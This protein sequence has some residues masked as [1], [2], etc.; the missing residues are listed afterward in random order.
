MMKTENIF[1]IVLIFCIFILVAF[2]LIHPICDPDIFFH[3]GIGRYIFENLK[4]PKQDIFSYTL[5]G[6]EYID[7]HWL[8]QVMIYSIYKFFNFTGLIIFKTILVLTTIFLFFNISYKKERYLAAALTFFLPILILQERSDFRPE[9][10][11][12]F[13]SSVYIYIINKKERLMWLIPFLQIFW[14]NLHGNLSPIGLAI[15]FF[16]ALSNGKLYKILVAAV[17]SCIINPWGYKYFYFVLQ[18]VFHIFSKTDILGRTIGEFQKPFGIQ[19]MRSSLMF[20]YF[21]LFSTAIFVIFYIRK[22]STSELLIY[23]S[24]VILSF[25]AVRNIVLFSFIV[26]PIVVKILNSL[27]FIKPLRYGLGALIIIFCGYF[28]YAITSNKVYYQYD[29]PKKFG[30]GISETFFQEK[31]CKFILEKNIEGNIFH[32]MATGDSI[33]LWLYPKKKVFIDA[34]PDARIKVWKNLAFTYNNIFLN[35]EFFKEILNRYEIN[36]IFL[37]YTLPLANMLYQKVAKFKDW[38]LVYYDNNSVIFLRDTKMGLTDGTY[39]SNDYLTHLFRAQFYSGLEDTDKALYE[40]KRAIILNPNS[41]IANNNLGIIYLQKDDYE[42]ALF[43][44][45]KALKYFKD[46]AQIYNNLGII[47]INTREF[48]KARETLKVGIRKNPK[49]PQL[50]YN[51]GR[52]CQTKGFIEKATK[53][54]QIALQ[55]DPEYESP[56]RALEELYEKK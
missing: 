28:S 42:N 27:K 1:K 49:I 30:F 40:Y 31:A 35:M 52:L 5:S 32:D 18:I 29:I 25:Q 15:I 26:S 10:V 22:L 7:F 55:L 36:C 50:H 37:N 16:Y 2:F 6:A 46:S 23:V 38:K 19:Q 33:I 17:F 47:Y 41:A 48:E 12:L 4:I 24:F 53:E 9:V 54:Y 3:L 56:R 39:D 45:N 51:Y 14:V 34:C 21:F 43:H 44:F 20:Y 11:S 8:F 13:F